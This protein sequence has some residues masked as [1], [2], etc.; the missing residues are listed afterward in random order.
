MPG[1]DVVAGPGAERRR[2]DCVRIFEE[3]FTSINEG[4]TWDNCSS[5]VL[6]R[7]SNIPSADLGIASWDLEATDGGTGKQAIKLVDRQDNVGKV[8]ADSDAAHMDEVTLP[9]LNNFTCK[10]YMERKWQLKPGHQVALQ[11][12]SPL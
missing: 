7:S 3:V 9:I 12:I 10:L 11:S 2:Q 6:T 4:P 8:C 1:S 5:Q